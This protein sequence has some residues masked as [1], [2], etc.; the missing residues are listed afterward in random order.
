[1]RWV[2]VFALLIGI[3]AASPAAAATFTVTST[4]DAADNNTADGICSGGP[5]VAN[6]CTLRAAIQQAGQ[7]AGADGITLPAGNYQLA[8]ALGQL[9]VDSSVVISG[10]GARQTTIRAGAG[11]RV[12]SANGS[13]TLRDLTLTGGSVNHASNT[14]DFGGG[15]RVTGGEALL[16]RVTVRDNTITSE[17]GAYGG[18][19]GVDAGSVTVIDST[20]SGNT[21]TAPLN[22]TGT[23]SGGGIYSSTPLTVR[24]STIAGNL[25]RNYLQQTFSQGAG[26]FVSAHATIE[27]S[28]I[29]GNSAEGGIAAQQGGGLFVS[30]NSTVSI[31]GTIF[32]GNNA[33]DNGSNC[34]ASAGSTI[35]ETSRNLVSNGDCFGSAQNSLKNTNPQLTAL[36]DNGG[37]TDTLR[38]AN[39]SPAVNAASSCGTR[40]ADQRGNTP[41]PAGAACD[42]GAVEVGADRSVALQSS[43]SSAAAGEDV[44]L[45]ATVSNGSLGDAATDEVVTLELPAGA[46]AT[47]ATST[48]GACTAGATVSCNLGTL[49]RGAA[50][51]ITAVVKGTGADLPITART[52]GPVPD[53]APGSNAASLT[54]AGAGGPIIPGDPGTPNGPAGDAIAPAI[55]GLKL[56]KKPTTKKG[57]TLTFSLS[58]PGKVTVVVER[59]QAGRLKGSKC[60]AG[61]KKGK[62]CTKYTAVKKPI[63]STQPGGKGS[64]KLPGSKLKTGKLRFTVTATDAAGNISSKTFV[65]GTIK[66]R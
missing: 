7:I 13:V 12:A 18:G 6:A 55:T 32:A 37:P 19:I 47:L 51:T 39:G 4:V 58:E 40:T 29:V 35:T 5:A 54:I 46:S 62:R 36:Q 27:H 53:P 43:K 52:T 33:S 61:R 31:G 34:F 59:E 17:G 66:K 44:T 2:A 16:E 21:A 26:I 11:R 24:R 22:T 25:T 64:I 57:A 65:R 42:L 50:A 20:I 49:S 28:T 1:M 41:L 48:L 60:V 9:E 10:G 15:L 63:V 23:G 3:A 38:P 8:V 14:T 56:S 45:I 30:G